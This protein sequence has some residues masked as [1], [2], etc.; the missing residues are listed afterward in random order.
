MKTAGGEISEMKKFQKFTAGCLGLAFAIIVLLTGT[1]C[2]NAA[3]DTGANRMN[4][5]FVLDQSGSMGRTDAQ[6][7]RYEAVDLFMGLSAEQGNYMGA[8]VFDDTIILQQDLQEMS[9]QS[10]KKGLSDSIRQ[11]DSNGD[12]DIGKAVE[13]ATEMLVNNG[14]QSLPSAIILLSDGNTDLPKDTTGD[15]LRASETSRQ[16]AINTARNNGIKVHSVCLNANGTAKVEELRDIS[17]ATGG[18]CVEVKSAEDLKTVFNQFYNIIFSTDTVGLAD[19]VIPE[20]GELK[21]A[22]E[23]P[24]FGVEEANIII[25]TLNPETSYNLTNPDGHGYTQSEMEAME[26]KAETF[27][28][29]KIQAPAAGDWDLLVRGVAGDQVKVD[30]VY[31]TD[32]SLVLEPDKDLSSIGN[33]EDVQMTAYLMNQ[34]VKVDKPEA[35]QEYP[36]MLTVKNLTS[37]AEEENEMPVNGTECTLTVTFDEYADYKVQAYCK[38]DDMTVMSE[39]FDASIGNTPPVFSE[40]PIEISGWVTPFS[41]HLT[42][43]LSGYV[44]DAEDDVSELLFST[45]NE[46]V[47]A[48]TLAIQG[49]DLYVN[50]KNAGKGGSFTLVATDTNGASAETE[51]IVKLRSVLPILIGIIAFIVFVIVLLI[52]LKVRSNG[53]KVI[54]GQIQVIGFNEYG[55]VGAAVTFDGA[56]GKN[57]ILGR[58]ADLR[59]DVGMNLAQTFL[60]ADK[61]SMNYI[62]LTS[63]TGYYTDL[64]PGV[65]L[66]R[67]RLDADMEVTVSADAE[68]EKGIRITY[69][70]EDMGY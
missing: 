32:L 29:I 47:G 14:N 61:K 9:G 44:S 25:S 33:G 67:I 38:V 59:G 63:K 6:A 54:R 58:Y 3:N 8:V 35:Y 43:D 41:N 20:G 13:L 36:I 46:N 17:D 1:V 10:A 40:N 24:M 26:I 51:V 53:K 7:L 48:D 31:N 52:I 21:V 37:G 66:K 60:E 70:P 12:T 68:Q 69:I 62:Y 49:T 16:N 64:N 4:V 55:T 42:E 28:I 56:R 5:V 2:A 27:T 50:M 23:V 18:T 34:G 15:A 19:T 30:M 39:E 22:F 57:M 45:A 65:R 11:A